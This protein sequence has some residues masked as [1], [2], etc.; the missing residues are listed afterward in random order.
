MKNYY[1][2]AEILGLF[3]RELLVKV[4]YEGAENCLNQLENISDIYSILLE[5]F[6][7]NVMTKTKPIDKTNKTS[8]LFMLPDYNLF[9][10]TCDQKEY[11]TG[12]YYDNEEDLLRSERTVRKSTL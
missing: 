5:F 7:L 10:I 1:I 9:I 2:S 12:R 8:D 3:L 4:G 11:C 6:D